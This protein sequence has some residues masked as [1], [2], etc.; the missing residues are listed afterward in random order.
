MRGK[1]I[2]RIACGT[3]SVCI[4]YGLLM[5]TLQGLD[6]AQA[7]TMAWT[8]VLPAIA[9]QDVQSPTVASDL[10]ILSENEA[11][12]EDRRTGKSRGKRGG[13]SDGVWGGSRGTSSALSNQDEEERHTQTDGDQTEQLAAASAQQADASGEPPT[14]AQFLSAL[15][16]SGCRH[17]CSLFS[18]RCMKGRSKMQTAT[19]EYQQTYGG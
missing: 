3:C 8:T 2:Y 16:C 11:L 7:E 12:Y 14:L 15:R 5:Q 10:L 13:Q 18:P 9:A 1:V 4:T 19:A 17:N 6:S